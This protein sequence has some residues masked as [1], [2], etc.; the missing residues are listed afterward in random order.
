V[1]HAL[2]REGIGGKAFVDV[3]T[4]LPARIR[5]QISNVIS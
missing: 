4:H 2:A 5:D 3:K 1:Q